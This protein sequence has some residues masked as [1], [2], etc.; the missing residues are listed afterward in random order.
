MPSGRALSLTVDHLKFL[1]FSGQKTQTQRFKH[2]SLRLLFSLPLTVWTLHNENRP[3][4]VEIDERGRDP[5]REGDYCNIRFNTPYCS[6]Y[7]NNNFRGTFPTIWLYVC[8]NTNRLDH[9]CVPSDVHHQ[10]S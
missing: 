4:T 8:V 7:G 1:L 9:P 10:K 3:H 2:V 6:A 5:S